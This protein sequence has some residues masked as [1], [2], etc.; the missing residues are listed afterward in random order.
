MHD[1]VSPQ[2]ENRSTATW[3][4]LV[5]IGCKSHVPPTLPAHTERPLKCHFIFSF[6]LSPPLPCTLFS[7]KPLLWCQLKSELKI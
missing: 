6:F 4:L 5:D 2:P 7:L 3:A 1:G